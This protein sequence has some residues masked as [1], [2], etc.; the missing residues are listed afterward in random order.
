[1]AAL[2]W[3]DWALLAVLGVSVLVGLW[4]GLVYELMSLV[5][6]LVAYVAAQLWSGAVAPHL[7]FGT[8][9]SALQQGLAFA[10]TF[11]ATLLAW[12]LLARL[13]RLL[14]QATPLTLIDRTLGAGFGLLRG[15]VLLLALATVVALTPAVRSP[16]WQ[17]SQGAEWLAVL[18]QGLRPV[19]PEAVARHLPEPPGGM[20]RHRTD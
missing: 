13:V 6:W 8:P 16:A 7:P 9:G 11:V 18:L 12:A 1:M 5:G 10:I 2:G 14:I 17:A 20:P 4:R 19:L 15:G 3:V